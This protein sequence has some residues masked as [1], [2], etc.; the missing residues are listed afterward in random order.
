[1]DYSQEIECPGMERWLLLKRPRVS[2]GT[3]PSEKQ[4]NIL[5]VDDESGTR[6][7]LSTVLRLQG[8]NTQFA[9]DGDEAL[10]LFENAPEPFDL[11]ITDHMMARVSGLDLVRSLRKKGFHGDIVVLTAYAGSIEEEEYK[12]LE[13]AG[14]MGKPFDLAELRL[15]L[16][17]IH[18]S[19]DN[20]QQQGYKEG[21]PSAITFCWLKHEE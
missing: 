9:A 3:L 8:H 12:R 2:T 11:I 10:A 16:D 5:V 14:I 4:L 6:T 19:R 7:A 21:P 18:R 1:M 20:A 13:V 17:C 15:W